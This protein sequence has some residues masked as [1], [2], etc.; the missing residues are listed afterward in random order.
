LIFPIDN[1]VITAG[2]R[3]STYFEK[4]H[5][6]H[7]GTDI[8]AANGSYA[9]ILA[10]GDG[11]V[12]G[13]EFCDNSL[14]NIAV[15]RYDNVFVPE[16]GESISLI[17]RYYHMTSVLVKKEEIVHVGQIIGTIDGG[18]KWYH[19]VHLELDMDIRH[20]FFTPQVAEA[21][22]ELLQRSNATGGF[23]IEPMSILVMS[24]DQRIFAHPNSDCCTEKDAPRFAEQ[25]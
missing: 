8:T 23:I 25:R 10:S 13:T 22:S 6:E 24:K 17:A 11:V 21:T 15:I 14:G 1:G 4:N 5:F 2:Y 18:H 3:N 19:H 12:L 20:P 16:T 7:Y 9:E